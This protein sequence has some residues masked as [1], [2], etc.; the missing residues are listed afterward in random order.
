[1]GWTV[2]SEKKETALFKGVRRSNR[3]YWRLTVIGE[4]NRNQWIMPQ[5]AE[6]VVKWIERSFFL[7]CAMEIVFGSVMISKGQENMDDCK[8]GVDAYLYSVGILL[9]VCNGFGVLPFL[10]KCGA[11]NDGT[12]ACML[13]FDLCALV[14][15]FLLFVISGIINLIWGSYVIFGSYPSWNKIYEDT[16][17]ESETYCPPAPVE[18]GFSFLVV[19]WVMTPLTVILLV[20]ILWRHISREKAERDARKQQEEFKSENWRK[21]MY[22]KCSLFIN[23]LYIKIFCIILSEVIKWDF[24]A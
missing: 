1:M 15:G 21:F 14:I 11:S 20:Y 13:C 17:K 9:V 7:V 22:A 19:N 18:I 24:S 4:R 6:E 2:W 5:S 10:W 16:D 3:G 12:N 23:Y 8:N